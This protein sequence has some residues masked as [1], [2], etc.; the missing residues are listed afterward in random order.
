MEENIIIILIITILT[1]FIV[2]AIWGKVPWKTVGKVKLTIL[3]IVIAAALIPNLLE[4][5]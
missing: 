2:W 5:L 1:F 4:S 3:V